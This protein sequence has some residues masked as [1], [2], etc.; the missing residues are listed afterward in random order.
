MSKILMEKPPPIMAKWTKRE[1]RQMIWV[2][3]HSKPKVVERN[4]SI[5]SFFVF[6]GIPT[7]IKTMGVNIT[8]I[9]YLRVLIIEIGS[10][11]ILMVV[12]A[13]G[14][15]LIWS[16]FTLSVFP[17]FLLGFSPV[18]GFVSLGGFSGFF[19]SA[20]APIWIFESPPSAK[21]LSTEVV[22]VSI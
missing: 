14:F 7:T 1:T 10:T 22:L 3:R 21:A 8:T 9:D 18:G 15:V 12:E 13:Q 19:G 17:G 11:I 20:W 4:A 16:G 5:Y 6:P 2:V